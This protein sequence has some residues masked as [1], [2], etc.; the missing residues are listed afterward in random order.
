MTHPTRSHTSSILSDCKSSKLN[1]PMT[2]DSLSFFNSCWR[3]SH[4]NGAA[5][6][7]KTTAVHVISNSKA[8]IDSQRKIDVVGCNRDSLS[9]S[10][11]DIIA[12]IDPILGNPANLIKSL[13]LLLVPLTKW[14]SIKDH[15]LNHLL[16][17]VLTRLINCQTLLKPVK[18]IVDPL[19][20]TNT[21]YILFIPFSSFHSSFLSFSFHSRS[22][23]LFDHLLIVFLYHDTYFTHK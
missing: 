4:Q 2:N 11:G 15:S 5:L 1:F 13:L 9:N 21:N 3:L 20:Q 8:S 7:D 22:T 18:R 10:L 12:I 16:K 6:L 19:N 14:K 23:I 17:Q